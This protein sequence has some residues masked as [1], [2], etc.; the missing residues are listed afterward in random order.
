MALS[1]YEQGLIHGA[2]YAARPWGVDPI[3]EHET[4]TTQEDKDFC[5]FSCPHMNNCAACD[6][7]DGKGNLRAGVGRPKK[8]IDVTEVVTM[9][10]TMTIAEI[11]N[12]LG[13]G[14]MTIYRAIR[15]MA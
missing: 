14:K 1:S 9:R 15:S 5:L 2:M 4:G 12:L 11:C 8:K 10:E 3:V 13:V 6:K 7:C